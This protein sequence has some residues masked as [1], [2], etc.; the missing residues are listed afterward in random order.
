VGKGREIG[1]Y[2]HRDNLNIKWHITCVFSYSNVG[3]GR[4][5][6]SYFHIHNSNMKW[7]IPCAFSYP[8]RWVGR[9]KEVGGK[10]SSI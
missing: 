6:V 1:S 8:K 7:H 9:E 3:R 5:V 4:E 2:L 10:A